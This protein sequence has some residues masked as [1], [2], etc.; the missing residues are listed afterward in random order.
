MNILKSIKPS[1]RIR[2]P[3]LIEYIYQILQVCSILGLF[4][5][6]LPTQIFCAGICKT[7]FQGQPCTSTLIQFISCYSQT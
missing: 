1:E 7:D 4:T 5:E 6:L 3:S 2:G